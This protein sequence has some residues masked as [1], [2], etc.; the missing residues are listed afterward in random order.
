ITQECLLMFIAPVD[1]WR[2]I[3]LDAELLD[4]S[5]CLCK[6]LSAN[7]FHLPAKMH[8][9]IF[10]GLHLILTLSAPQGCRQAP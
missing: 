9:K 2:F 3:G 1:R 7:D 6:V 10:M 8:I 5:F 4:L